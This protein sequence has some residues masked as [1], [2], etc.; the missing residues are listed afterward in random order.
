[1]IGWDSV[2]NPERPFAI[3]MAGFAVSLRRFH[4][5]AHARFGISEE[6]RKWMMESEFLD[7]MVTMKELEPMSGAC[8]KVSACK[9][10]RQV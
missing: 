4:E 2:R 5:K 3:D 10:R 8:T 6:A 9:S 7:K 1:M